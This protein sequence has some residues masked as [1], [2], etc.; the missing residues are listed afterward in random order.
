[1]LLLQFSE[2]ATQ[3]RLVEGPQ[4]I[5]LDGAGDFPA[6]RLLLHAPFGKP[7]DAAGSA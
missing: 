5:D 4:A 6:F 2:P 3:L 1:L 7:G